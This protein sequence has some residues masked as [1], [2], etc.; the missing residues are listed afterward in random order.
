[1]LQP[2]RHLCRSR[3]KIGGDDSEIPRW[4]TV[5][6]VR[7]EEVKVLQQKGSRKDKRL[8]N[9]PAIPRR[10]NFWTYWTLNGVD[11]RV[12]S[13]LQ[14]FYNRKRKSLEVHIGAQV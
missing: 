7:M 3:Q 12:L 10:L 5:W 2:I 8:I 6:D 4:E 14:A 9:G 13:Q 1:M 11:M